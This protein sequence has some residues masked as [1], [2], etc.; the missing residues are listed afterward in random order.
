MGI[1][2]EQRILSLRD[3][4]SF[5]LTDAACVI[6]LVDAFTLNC[7]Q[8]PHTPGTLPPYRGMLLSTSYVWCSSTAGHYVV[9]LDVDAALSVVRVMDPSVR[10]VREV[11]VDVFEAS[12]H[13]YGTDDDV[14]VLARQ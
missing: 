4:R 7:I 2:V 14:V 10:T 5:L 6:A 3:I 9:V 13:A 8:A 12:R 1:I 11:H